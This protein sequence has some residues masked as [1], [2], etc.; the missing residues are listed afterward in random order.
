[1]VYTNQKH[2]KPKNK[3]ETVVRDKR[4]CQKPFKNPDPQEKGSKWGTNSLAAA[5]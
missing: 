5:S 2:S 1:V 4:L 3:S